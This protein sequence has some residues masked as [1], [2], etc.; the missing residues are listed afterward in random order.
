MAWGAGLTYP[1]TQVVGQADA[2]GDGL[3]VRLMAATQPQSS[4]TRS[5]GRTTRHGRSGPDSEATSPPRTAFP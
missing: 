2:I 5:R 4:P 3:G 1:G